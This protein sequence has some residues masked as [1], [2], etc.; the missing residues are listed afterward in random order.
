MKLSDPNR[1]SQIYGLSSSENGI[2]RYIGKTIKSL[3][4]RLSEHLYDSRH[5]E[6]S[7]C[8]DS[9]KGNWIRRVEEDGFYIQIQTI[10]ETTVAEQNER[11]KYWIK[12]Y[13]RENLVNGTDGGETVN[14]RK[15]NHPTVS[16]ERIRVCLKRNRK[17]SFQEHL[18]IIH[19]TKYRTFSFDDV[20]D[21]ET[22]RNISKTFKL[23]LYKNITVRETI[24]LMNNVINQ[25]VA[26]SIENLKNLYKKN[27]GIVSV[28]YE[29]GWLYRAF[30]IPKTI[31]SFEKMMYEIVEEKYYG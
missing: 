13:G 1:Y 21:S 3:N 30:Y 31:K 18:E 11:E 22:R 10:E 16:F 6:N 7:L 9:H 20:L 26:E 17:R 5:P 19:R 25:L 14:L 8:P 12:Y 28:A 23:A 29:N 2:I 15:I 4:E 27:K 24:D